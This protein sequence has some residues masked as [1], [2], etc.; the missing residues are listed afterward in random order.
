M[1]DLVPDLGRERDLGAGVLD[2]AEVVEGA[3]VGALE[4]LAAALQAGEGLLAAFEGAAED[5]VFGDHPGEH[6]V[7][8]PGQPHG[9]EIVFP[10]LSF[11]LA[12]AAEGPL[13]IDEDVDEGALGGGLGLVIK[14]VLSRQGVESG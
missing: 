13:G 14:K 10:E 2:R 6:Q 7:L 12:E 1:P 8:Q 11:G 3:V 9:S 5:L 4:A